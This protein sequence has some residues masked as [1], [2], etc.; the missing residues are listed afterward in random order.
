MTT[1][2]IRGVAKQAKAILRGQ[3]GILNTLQKEHEVVAALMDRVASAN[4]SKPDRLKAAN[5]HYPTIRTELLSHARAEQRVFY[6]ACLSRAETAVLAGEFQS[7]HTQIEN[8]LAELDASSPEDGAWFI[9][10]RT[11]QQEVE[12]HVHREENELFPLCKDAF[13]D[14]YLRGLD[15][16][17]RSL[18]SE[19]GETFAESLP[20]PPNRPHQTL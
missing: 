11:L 4:A 13:D 16:H 18:K 20:Y 7:E 3:F 9:T 10:F 2:K 8:L 17:Y 6:E 14:K 1:E 5:K 15:E 19:L 12:H